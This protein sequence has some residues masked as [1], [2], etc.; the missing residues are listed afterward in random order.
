MGGQHRR[1]WPHP[2]PLARAICGGQVARDTQRGP[3][4][5]PGGAGLSGVLAAQEVQRV[6]ACV[7]Y[8]T[9]YVQF[10]PLLLLASATR[11][12]GLRAL[13]SSHLETV[14]YD[15]A[16][17]VI[18]SA[19]GTSLPPQAILTCFRSESL[20]GESP[21]EDLLPLAEMLCGEGLTY[22]RTRLAPLPSPSRGYPL[23]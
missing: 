12:E 8:H 7:G 13:S 17:S 23:T 11:A 2:G 10:D 3:D 9:G 5:D 4:W 15:T 14:N 20:P 19:R 22:Y 1:R 21:G 16:G 6:V 18:C